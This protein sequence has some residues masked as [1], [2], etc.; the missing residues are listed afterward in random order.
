MTEIPNIPEFLKQIHIFGVSELT[1]HIK[2]RLTS[3]PNLQHIAV[4]GEVSNFTKSQAGHI[5]FSLKDSG[6]QVRCVSFRSRA[7]R[8]SYTPKEGDEVI[9]FGSIDVYPQGG[10]YQLYVDELFHAGRGELFARYLELKDQLEKE[11]LFNIERKKPIPEYPHTVGVVTSAKGA[12]VRDILKIINNRAPHVRIVIS[13][14]L[15][16]GE[17]APSQIIAALE[18]LLY[19]HPM[20]DTVILARGGGSFEDLF[21]F[22]DENLARFVAEYPIPIITGVGHET[23][24]TIVDF[25]SDHRS[26]TPTAA[27]HDAVPDRDLL[28]EEVKQLAV[29]W[30]D[31]LIEG[32]SGYREL[33]SDIMKRP[34]FL[35]P[36]RRWTIFYQEIDN[37]LERTKKSVFIKIRNAKAEV[38]N[39]LAILDHTNP[40]KLLEKGYSLTYKLPERH[41]VTDV[42]QL[43]TGDDV[44]VKLWKGRFNAEIKSTEND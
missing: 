6:S 21:C 13:P 5:Y 10:A 26:P 20:P 7:E 43:K 23:D 44:T 17:E 28:I 27:A 39:I 41:L 18:K 34:V 36:E 24:F 35:H 22:N 8:L 16:Q 32:I 42:D 37:L 9:V 4:K 12:A 1:G 40:L 25:V 3:D 38:E 11:G 19:I 2:D 30:Y 14:A 31:Y 29:K 33:V 15:V